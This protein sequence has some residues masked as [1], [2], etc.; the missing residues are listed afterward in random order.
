MALSCVSQSTCF[1]ISTLLVRE[2]PRLLQLED[3]L[4]SKKLTIIQ[5]RG[6]NQNTDFDLDDNDDVE[7]DDGSEDSSEDYRPQVEEDGD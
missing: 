3:M 2:D 5:K 6:D 7:S 4:D 1:L